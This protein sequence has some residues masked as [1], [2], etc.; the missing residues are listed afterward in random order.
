[1]AALLGSL[2]P[3]HHAAVYGGEQGIRLVLHHGAACGRHH[4]GAVAKVLT[5]S[6]QPS[7][8]TDPD[9]VIQFGSVETYRR[10]A[11]TVIP[12]CLSVEQPALALVELP[13]LSS[14]ERLCPARFSAPPDESGQLNCL[15]STILLI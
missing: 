3:A 12:A 6:A 14:G 9:H 5:F 1:M 11:Q 7:T 13:L 10:Q 4:H 2:D 15:R 8:P